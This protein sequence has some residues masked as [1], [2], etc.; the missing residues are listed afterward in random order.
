MS[1][2]TPIVNAAEKYVNSL[3]VAWASNT[4]LTMAAGAARDRNNVMDLILSTGV[5]I[6]CAVNGLNALDT[7]TLAANTIYYVYIIGASN[8]E[9][10]VGALVS[11]SLTA[12]VLP[13]GYDSWRLIDFQ[14][15]DGSSHFLLNYN[16]GA[17]NVRTK[18]YDSRI[19]VLNAG[20]SSS[21]ALVTCA[22][23]VPPFTQNL[24]LLL[25]IEFIPATASQYVYFT[26]PGST[27]TTGAIRFDG[28]VAA[29]P[30]VGQM[31][32]IS[33]LSSGAQQFQYSNNAGSC[34]TTIYVYG[35]EFNI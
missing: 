30:N 10:P 4:T 3:Q 11:T 25:N 24:K 35:V 29:V 6:N 28:I 5:T 34:S 14:I 17:Y 31:T 7:G 13:F 22:A 26:Y 21:S 32:L 19:Q 20:S 8:G 33:G 1:Q 15:T 12:P 16:V 27:A 18:I 2:L 9:Q 23:A